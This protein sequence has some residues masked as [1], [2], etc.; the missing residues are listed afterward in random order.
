MSDMGVHIIILLTV[1]FWLGSIITNAALLTANLK[2]YTEIMK[3]RKLTK[4]ESEAG[5]DN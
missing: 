1:I 3:V 5:D 4:Q 2:I